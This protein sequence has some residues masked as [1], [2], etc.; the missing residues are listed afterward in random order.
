AQSGKYLAYQAQLNRIVPFGSVNGEH[1]TLAEY[2]QKCQDATGIAIPSFSCSA[3]TDV[4]GQGVI[5]ATSPNATHCDEPNVLNRECDPGSRFEV[6]PGGN[7]DAVAVAHCRKVG[8]PIAGNL[9]NDI[10]IIQYNKKNGAMC[11]YQALTNLPGDNIP[12]PIK[13][14]GAP[15]QD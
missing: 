7:A 1:D 3:G 12:A 15:W 2:A 10:A 5:P 13:G 9:Y 6:R 8:L 14:D 11:F 4:P